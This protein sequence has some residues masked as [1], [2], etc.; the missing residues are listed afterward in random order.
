MKNKQ[1]EELN[2]EEISQVTQLFE[3]VS[4][5]CKGKCNTLKEFYKNHSETDFKFVKE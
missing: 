3:N 2:D 4:Y 1:F 5:L